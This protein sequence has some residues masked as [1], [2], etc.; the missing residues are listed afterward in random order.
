MKKEIRHL[1][2]LQDCI[3][4]LRVRLDAAGDAEKKVIIKNK[5]YA[6]IALTKQKDKLCK[7]GYG[8]SINLL[9]TSQHQGNRV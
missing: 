9:Q 2:D 5:M 1:A 4:Y 6:E 7:A 3:E 8:A